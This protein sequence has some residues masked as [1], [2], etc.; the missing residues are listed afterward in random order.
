M[1]HTLARGTVFDVDERSIEWLDGRKS[2]DLDFVAV[3]S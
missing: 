1:A 3:F 2:V